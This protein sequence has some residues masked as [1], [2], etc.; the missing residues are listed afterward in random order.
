MGRPGITKEEVAAAVTA[1]RAQ[2]RPTTTRVVRLEVGRGSYATI[3]RFLDALGA[4]SAGRTEKLDEMPLDIQG[5]LADCVFSMW[6]AVCEATSR[7][8]TALTAQCEQRIQVLSGELARERELRKKVERELGANQQ[9][10]S[11]ARLEVQHLTQRVA[12]LREQ[13]AGEQAVVK[14]LERDREELLER[15][16]SAAQLSFPRKPSRGRRSKTDGA[17][18]QAAQHRKAS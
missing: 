8:Q 3:S 13:L 9:E 18:R 16:G 11:A 5:R 2:G 1:L 4:K 12:M 15:F 6:Q 17:R 14:R 10:L 7:A